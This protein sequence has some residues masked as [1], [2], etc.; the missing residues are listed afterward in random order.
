VETVSLECRRAIVGR[1]DVEAV[2]RAAGALARANGFSPRVAE[3][4]LLMTSELAENVL[5][6]SSGGEVAVTIAAGPP[7]VI[8]VEA[9]DRGPGMDDVRKV[10]EAGYST[11]TGLGQG[12]AL[13][14]RM[15][16]TVE[17]TSDSAGTRIRATRRA[18]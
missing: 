3:E 12:L 4:V 10:F 6:H 1:V 15:A 8:A 16:D 5:V 7:A 14:R 13:V 18:T 2:R 17:I 9:T 11:S